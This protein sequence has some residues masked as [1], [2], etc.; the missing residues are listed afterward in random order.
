MFPRILLVLVAAAA[1][2]TGC[3][4]ETT[5]STAPTPTTIPIERLN[6]EQLMLPRIDFC[7]LVPAAAV[8]RALG[9]KAWK[10]HDWHNGDQARLTAGREDVVAEHLCQW[11]AKSGQSTARAWMFARPVSA[12]FAREV[13]RTQR[14]PDSEGRDCRGEPTPYF[15]SPSLLQTCPGDVVRV[16][17]AGLFHDT[18]LTCEVSDAASVAAVRQRADDWCSEVATNLST[19]R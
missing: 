5:P 14:R 11:S 19:T 3:R 2:L 15:G 4:G 13:I 16:R 8:D 10:V 18:W 9:S 17:R 12:K 7:T 1:L 6:T